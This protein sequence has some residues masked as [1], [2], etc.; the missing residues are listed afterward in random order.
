MRFSLFDQARIQSEL[1]GAL[2]LLL[3]DA[4][5]DYERF[6]ENIEVWFNHGM[7]RVS[8]WYKRYTQGILM[9]VALPLTMFV[10]ADSLD[11]ACAIWKDP[12]VRAAL[13][14][15]AQN[16]QNAPPPPPAEPEEIGDVIAGADQYISSL[17][18]VAAV[19]DESL[20][21]DAGGITLSEVG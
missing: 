5:G 9:A 4:Q 17:R 7:E 20:G 2:R 8:G 14:A 3:S 21:V 10:N 19:N 1:A 6:V 13:V 16:L 11:I 18:A 15:D 12:T